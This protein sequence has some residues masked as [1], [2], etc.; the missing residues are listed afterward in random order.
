M[1][2]TVQRVIRSTS[3]LVLG[4]VFWGDSESNGDISGWINFKLAAVLIVSNGRFSATGHPIH[5]MYVCALYSALWH[6]TSL[7]T[8]LGHWKHFARD[9]MKRKE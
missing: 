1:V 4:W 3:C 5:F 2:I 6:Y 7:L 9:G 8:V